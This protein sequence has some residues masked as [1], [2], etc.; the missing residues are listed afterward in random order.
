[1]SNLFNKRYAHVDTFTSVLNLHLFDINYVGTKQGKDSFIQQNVQ[2]LSFANEAN[3]DDE[4]Y[5]CLEGI[6]E[7]VVSQPDLIKQWFDYLKGKLIKPD[8]IRGRLN[9]ISVLLQQFVTSSFR[10]LIPPVLLA[11]KSLVKLCLFEMKERVSSDDM[12]AQGLLPNKGKSDLIKMWNVLCP[13]L[14]RILSLARQQVI[15]QNLYALAIQILFFGFYS[16][17]ANGRMQA[18]VCMT[19]AE[20]K[21]LCSKRY[22]TSN[23]TKS[24]TYRGKQLVCVGDDSY[25]LSKI[26]DY[27]HILR[28]QVINRNKSMADEDSNLAFLQ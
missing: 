4:D 6:V 13:L 10:T 5:E 24:R 14:D 20:C 16:E 21:Q 1:M 9:N 11:I 26:K 2:F 7:V 3:E 25:L 8:S 28:P 17:N 19:K 23:K 15:G 22:Y 12:V 18:I 27:M